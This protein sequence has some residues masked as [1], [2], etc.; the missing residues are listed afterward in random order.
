[1]SSPGS[2]TAGRFLSLASYLG[3]F[4]I[5]DSREGD[6]VSGCKDI[7]SGL[8]FRSPELSDLVSSVSEF[9]VTGRLILK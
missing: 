9:G 2:P 1:M 3:W 7:T 5:R 4:E 6:I 8:A